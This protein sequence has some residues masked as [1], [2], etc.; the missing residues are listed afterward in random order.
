MSPARAPNPT[1]DE[2]ADRLRQQELV[3]EFGM[4]VLR[5]HDLDSILKQACTAATEGLR[6]RH[7]KVL[8]HRAATSDFVVRAGIGWNPG[9]VGHATL[10]AGMD[11]PAGYAFHTSAPVLSVDLG[12]EDRFRL[13]PL[14]AEHGVR[15]AINVIVGVGADQP[16]GVLEVDSTH[17]HEFVE[18]DTAFMQ[19]LANTLAAALDRETQDAALRRSEQLARRIYESSPDC[20]KVLDRDGILLSINGNGRRLMQIS[21]ERALI[22]E[23]W[24]HLWP[25][26]ERENVRLAVATAS[27]GQIGHF[28]AMCP[29]SNG[30]HRWWDV[31]VAPLSGDAAAPDQV[32]AI[33]RDVTARQ[34]A[35]V[36]QEVLLRQ[37]D[38]LMRE[39]H[40]R[41]KNSLQLVR[42]LLHLQ[43][44][45]ASA[46]AREQLDEAAQ[47]IMTIGAVHQRLYEGGS[48]EETDAAA[49][50][51][52]LLSDM[53]GLLGDTAAGWNIRLD[54]EPMRLSADHVTPLGL[55]T[56]ELVTNALKYGGGTVQVRVR[57]VPDGV[58][59]QVEDEGVGFEPGFDPVCSRG[60]GMRLMLAM[61]RGDP[62]QAIR[63]DPDVPSRIAVTLTLNQ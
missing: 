30:E 11:S 2:L 44:R 31:L 57:R 21:D 35:K 39:V 6:T 16:F 3:A 50:L 34:Q 18:A 9:V 10:G 37:K 12:A 61:A 24:E 58:E 1:V 20:V 42:T 54:V 29:T 43:A 49:Y 5:D 38:L 36:A 40:H 48:V 60:L 25:E 33:S 22:G 28:E 56:T 7:A 15:S 41:V 45:T 53:Q 13:P 27:S 52:A 32:I 47:R 14:L 63:L 59:L 26:A 46:E 51:S 17:R 62:A 4:T 55:V 8:Q 19:A 23:P